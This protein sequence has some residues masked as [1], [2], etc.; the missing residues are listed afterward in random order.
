MLLF[1]YGI[2]GGI[3]LPKEKEPAD[4][5]LSGDTAGDERARALEM[6]YDA[7]RL[8]DKKYFD[9][10]ANAVR[11]NNPDLFFETCEKAG[12]DQKL[13]KKL[14]LMFGRSKNIKVTGW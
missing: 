3:L 7:N 14:W 8:L 12:I 2:S 6:A 4:D 1:V 11:N 13:A 9:D 5:K 10:F